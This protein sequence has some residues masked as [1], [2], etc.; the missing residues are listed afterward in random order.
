MDDEE[1]RK[2]FF[3]PKDQWT[4]PLSKEFARQNLIKEL[5]VLRCPVYFLI[6]KLD[7]QTNHVIGEAYY[8][9]IKAP[10]KGIFFFE[11]SGHVIPDSEPDLLQQ[12]MISAADAI[13]GG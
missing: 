10:K 12:D 9:Q 6:G 2:I 11:R 4:K 5:P 1:L 7:E 8:K 13:R 3:D